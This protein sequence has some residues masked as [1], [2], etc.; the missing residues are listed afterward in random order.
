MSNPIAVSRSAGLSGRALATLVALVAAL[1][2]AVVIAPPMLAANGSDRD[3]ANRRHLMDSLHAAFVTYW[4]SGDRDL[5]PD[6][7]R[8]VDYWFRFH[9]AK[10]AI[11]A[12]L[13]VVLVALG[14]LLWT[15][16]V[17]AGGLGL[18]RRAVL[19]SA[20]VLVTGFTLLSFAVVLANIQGAAAPFASLLPMVTE[21]PTDRA[22]TG[23]LD[24]IRQLLTAGDRSTPALQ[25]MVGDFTRYHAAF[26]VIAAIAAVAFISLSVLCWTRFAKAEPADRRSR[27]VL[28][29]FGVLSVLLSLTAILSVVANS[30]VAADSPRALLGLF[31]GGW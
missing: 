11:A 7:N 23:T 16:F 14:V 26:V 29:W 31:E 20:G 1:T 5:P 19:A 28:R 24:Q 30:S 9:V 4:R 2:A 27:R 18:G 13:L 3:L 12:I 17:R 21:R 22:L 8:V 15:A 6:L 25:A 10:A